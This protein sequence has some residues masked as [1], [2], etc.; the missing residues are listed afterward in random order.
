MTGEA[1]CAGKKQFTT[2][3]KAERSARGLNFF[4]D[5]AKANVYKCKVCRLWHVGNSMKGKSRG[6]RRQI[7]I[8]DREAFEE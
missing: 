8:N 4:R 2:Y 3:W 6:N 1:S 5:K 7:A